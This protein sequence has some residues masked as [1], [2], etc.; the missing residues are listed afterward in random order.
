MFGSHLGVQVNILQNF[1]SIALQDPGLGSQVLALFVD[2]VPA[3]QAMGAE[4]GLGSR[5]GYTEW[6]IISA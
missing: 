5:G 2:S 1:A 4:P 6:L 3:G